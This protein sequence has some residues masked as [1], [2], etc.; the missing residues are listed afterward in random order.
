MSGGAAQQRPWADQAAPCPAALLSL[1]FSQGVIGRGAYNTWVQSHV[2]QAQY[3]KAS[4]ARQ[5]R[6]AGWG[7]GW[8]RQLYAPSF[9]RLMG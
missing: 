4:M 5:G 8:Q 9:G 3:V 1:S 7:E 2:V 6:G